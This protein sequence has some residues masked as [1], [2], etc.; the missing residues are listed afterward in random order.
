MKKSRSLQNDEKEKRAAE[1]V[2]AN[3]ELK[4]QND[5]KEKRAAEL[6]IAN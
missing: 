1:L 2:I 3:K 5:E 4:F 6:V